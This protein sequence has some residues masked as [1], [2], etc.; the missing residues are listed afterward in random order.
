MNSKSALIFTSEKAHL[1]KKWRKFHFSLM[2]VLTLLIVICE[3]AM[4]FV[5]PHTSF[6][7]GT[8]KNYFV[9]YVLNTSVCY[10]TMNLLV[11]VLL[12]IKKIPDS[13]KNYI[14]SIGLALIFATVSYMHDFF[15]MVFAAGTIVITVTA[16]YCD[17]KITVATALVVVLS[18]LVNG[19]FGQWDT[20]TVKDSLYKSNLF[21]AMII[22]ASSCL[23][24]I[25]I[26]HWEEK[27]IAFVCE[28]QMEV[29]HFKELSRLDP[30]S[31][32]QNRL[33]L[34]A[35]LDTC[36]EKLSFAMAEIYEL[37]RISSE[38]GQPVKEALVANLGKLLLMYGSENFTAF[39]YSDNEFLL[40]FSGTLKP[41][42]EKICSRIQ[43]DF[44]LSMVHELSEI[45]C[46]M[47]VAPAFCEND[48][49]PP[50]L[51]AKAQVLLGSTRN[52]RK[53]ADSAKV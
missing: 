39:R 44:N 46:T 32:L 14:I 45:G 11:T 3:V 23:V 33:G 34:K 22:D 9:R 53:A 27:R 5:I 30:M 24:S 49:F 17:Y 6:L 13:V 26:I 15:V 36:T 29:S 19:L 28:K 4:F 7:E 41:D 48:E 35:F 47:L 21:F 2:V 38:W 10:I 8:I 51:I 1:Q 40:V 52:N 12:A 31:G 50:E 37:E 16:V 20:S 43:E 18:S 42:M 25:L